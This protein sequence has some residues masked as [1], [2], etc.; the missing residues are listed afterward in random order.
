MLKGIDF[1]P[2]SSSRTDSVSNRVRRA[3]QQCGYH[4][5]CGLHCEDDDGVLVLRGQVGS[6]YLKQIAQT[7]AARVPGIERID[8][9]LNVLERSNAPAGRGVEA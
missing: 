1:V 4:D 3:L 7:V 8:N 6:Y 9:Q 2:A 5:L